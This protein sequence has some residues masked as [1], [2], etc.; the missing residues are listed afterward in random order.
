MEEGRFRAEKWPAP[1]SGPTLTAMFTPVALALALAVA[2][3]AAPPSNSD[4]ALAPPPLVAAP[5]KPPPAP[6]VAPPPAPVDVP[7]APP[8]APVIVP[9]PAPVAAAAPP[10]ATPAPGADPAADESA[11]LLDRLLRLV[12]TADPKGRAAAAGALAGSGDARV[13][14]PLEYVLTDSHA[15]V[16]TAAARGLG[17]FPSPRVERALTQLARRDSEAFSVRTAAVEALAMHGTASS[18]DALYALW[19][20]D[21]APQAVREAARLGLEAK[22]P[23]LLASRPPPPPAP[24]P[25][26]RIVLG[27][28]G[29]AAGAFTLG[30]VGAYGQ[31]DLG[32][33][34]G[35]IGGLGA[36]AAAGFLLG[37][38]ATLPQAAYLTSGMAWGAWNGIALAG[39]TLPVT[40]ETRHWAAMG[41][42][43]MALGLGLTAWSWPHMDFEGGDVAVLNLGGLAGLGGTLGALLMQKPTGNLHPAWA[44][45]LLGSDVG[46]AAMVPLTR[47]LHFT[48]GDGMLTLFGTALGAT[49]GALWGVVIDDKVRRGNSE[50][51]RSFIG[52][53]F[54]LGAS[55]GLIGGAA[56]SQFTDYSPGEVIT[57][58][59]LSAYAHGVGFGVGTMFATNESGPVSVLAPALA[60]GALGTVGAGLLAPRLR[61]SGGDVASLALGTVWGFG[62]GL[63]ASLFLSERTTISGP[64]LIGIPLL[65]TS[66][67]GLG[68]LALNHA[69]DAGPIAVACS[70]AGAFWGAWYG[71]WIPLLANAELGTGG[72]TMALAADVGLVGAALLASPLV[73][74]PPL[75]FGLASL[76]GIGGA[77]FFSL[78]AAL[79][80]SDGKA[81]NSANL[82]GTTLG[83]AGGAVA[84]VLL[85][86]TLAP[87][88][89]TT[90]VALSLP[91][92][93]RNLELVSLAP[94]LH[95]SPDQRRVLGWGLEATVR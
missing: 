43:G 58:G 78:G 47:H 82:I 35:V 90:A 31:N 4:P 26:G 29:A 61:M 8:P 9:A 11:A 54:L 15:E 71:T 6:V 5:A 32:V 34:L 3:A 86:R 60:I 52:G 83:L 92:P 36:G 76:G 44:L 20:D 69:L 57:L 30:T 13:A 68:G 77:A 7:R 72:L 17:L 18:G 37:R 74:A 87:S 75:A 25:G 41:V 93:L 1:Q 46:I 59:V 27:I 67:G 45:A 38:D 88:R 49:Q 2:P 21:G 56:I 24:Q 16:R 62:Q 12:D 63:G 73:G 85:D 81:I 14:V 70:G 64:K 50:D 40:A 33:A 89:D 28:A 42:G 80:T 79:V 91:G 94:R 22:H 84:G 48:G 10:V 95:T 55:L 66:L 39:S 65:T 23:A 19:I 53:G 51:G